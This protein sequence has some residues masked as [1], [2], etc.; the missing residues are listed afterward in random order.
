MALFKKQVNVYMTLNFKVQAIRRKTEREKKTV[1]LSLLVFPYPVARPQGA[2]AHRHWRE[3][4]QGDAVL[5]YQ[6]TV[7]FN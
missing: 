6:S 2:A 1:G 7:L 4:K 3:A 5:S